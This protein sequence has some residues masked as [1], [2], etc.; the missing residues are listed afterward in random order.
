MSRRAVLAIAVLATS[1]SPV[2]ALDAS[3]RLSGCTVDTWRSRDG[4]PGAWVRAI[5]QTPDGYLWVGTQGG[6]AR[7]G[8][9]RLVTVLPDRAF[10]E[11]SDVQAL[12]AARDGALW[13]LPSR[14]APVCVRA[15]AFGPCFS[16]KFPEGGRLTGIDEDADGTIWLASSDG[17]L[18]VRGGRV[19]RVHVA[20][21]WGDATVTAVHHDRQGR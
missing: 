21:E 16:D 8:G 17:I 7:Y 12:H 13:I 3:K 15:G 2:L 11:A 5:V 6:L 4:L 14:G 1:T 18:R 9:G 10:E 20:A 19:E